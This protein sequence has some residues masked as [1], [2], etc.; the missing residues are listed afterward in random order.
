MRTY[1][2]SHNAVCPAPTH[3]EIKFGENFTP[4]QR[5]GYWRKFY[6]TNFLSYTVVEVANTIGCYSS[7]IKKRIL[8][9]SS[10]VQKAKL[11]GKE[12]I[13][14]VGLCEYTR[15]SECDTKVLGNV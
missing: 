2:L 12:R 15:H 9:V 11:A 5:T 6:S 8:V 4:I 13:Q 1:T 14:Q 3:G 10:Q 7:K